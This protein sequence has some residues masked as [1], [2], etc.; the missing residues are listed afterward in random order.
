MP[1]GRAEF[2]AMWFP[3]PLT[4]LQLREKNTSY[5]ITKMNLTS[6][7]TGTQPNPGSPR[8]RTEPNPFLQTR[9]EPNPNSHRTRT[10]PNPNNEGS[11]PSLII[12]CRIN[13]G[14]ATPGRARSNDLAGRSTALAQALVPP[15]PTYCFASVIVWTENK[16]G[17]QLFWAKKCIRVTWL[18]D[19]GTS[20]WPGSFTAL[21]PPLRIKP[22]RYP[23]I[24][25]VHIV[26]LYITG[27]YIMI[28]RHKPIAT[29]G[30]CR[31]M[32]A[33]HALH[34]TYARI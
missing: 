13:S 20:K 21:A 14:G 28:T 3:I 10:E 8:T 29:R 25:L 16:K 12:S 2:C 33:L 1:C 9:T 4:T 17:C 11:F 19:F 15:S 30:Y 23:T 22:L 5:F 18:E 7:R 31:L 27:L 34:S 32:T 6:P 26:L 24:Q